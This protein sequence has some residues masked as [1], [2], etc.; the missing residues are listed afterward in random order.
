MPLLSYSSFLCTSTPFHASCPCILICTIRVRT[1]V[2]LLSMNMLLTVAHSSLGHD[3]M[4]L[5]KHADVSE[6]PAFCL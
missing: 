6:E 1:L 3:V 4:H 2:A 5:K